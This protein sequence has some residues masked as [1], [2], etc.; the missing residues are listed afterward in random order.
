MQQEYNNY[1][2]LENDLCIPTW[3]PWKPKDP[4]PGYAIDAG[5][6][7]YDIDKIRV[8]QRVGVLRLRR[9]HGLFRLQF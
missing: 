5:S 8:H 3:Y 1:R 4:S 9:V 6:P 7:H 2:R